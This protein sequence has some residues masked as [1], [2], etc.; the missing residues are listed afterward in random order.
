LCFASLK[1]FEGWQRNAR[2]VTGKSPIPQAYCEDCTRQHQ[3]QMLLAG[4][5]ENPG[6]TPE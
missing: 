5:C 4:R 6:Y 2:K 1:D 3:W